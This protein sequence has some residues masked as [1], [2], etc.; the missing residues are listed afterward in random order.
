MKQIF[1]NRKR[2]KLNTKA[3]SG[4]PESNQQQAIRATQR[5]RFAGRMVRDPQAAQ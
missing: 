1:A 5:R 3:G 4:R 2:K